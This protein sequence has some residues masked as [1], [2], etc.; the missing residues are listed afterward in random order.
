MFEIKKYPELIYHLKKISNIYHDKSHEIIIFCPYCNDAT[1]KSNPTHGH[2]YIS[3]NSPVF[4]CFRCNA[5]GTILR[6]LLDTNFDDDNILKNISK[7]ISKSTKIIYHVVS[8]YQNNTIITKEYLHDY[9]RFKKDNK[10]DFLLF[11]RYISKRLGIKNG[12]RFLILPGYEIIKTQ[13]YLSCIFKNSEQKISTVKII[14]LN[15][16]KNYSEYYYFQE[17]NLT[18]FKQ[19]VITE[20]VFD[21]LNLYIYSNQFEESFFISANGKNYIGVIEYLM[22]DGLIFGNYCINIIFDSDYNFNP[23]LF[24]IKKFIS[25]INS[26]LS[27]KFF[28]PLIGKDTGVFPGVLEI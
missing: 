11:E 16:Y 21:L 6:L 26:N 9:L 27:V 28:K 23:L 14:N 15:T 4:Y 2:L 7:Q 1:R 17:K 10:S 25:Y 22:G 8:S 20:G 3:T 24:K 13:K 18:L 5:S 12:I 19:I